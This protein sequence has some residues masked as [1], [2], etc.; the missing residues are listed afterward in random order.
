MKDIVS[1]ALEAV[2]W[3]RKGRDMTRT[4]DEGLCLCYNGRTLD[5]CENNDRHTIA[6]ISA[7]GADTFLFICQTWNLFAVPSRRRSIIFSLVHDGWSLG[8]RPESGFVA[9]KDSGPMHCLVAFDADEHLIVRVRL[10]GK[11]IYQY[12]EEYLQDCREP[13]EK[14]RSLAIQGESMGAYA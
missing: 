2:G 12:R 13:V 3:Q 4:N 10:K 6:E 5:A 14:A 1:S 11:T 9:L 7:E 8:Y